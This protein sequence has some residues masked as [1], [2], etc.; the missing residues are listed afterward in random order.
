MSALLLL[1]YIQCFYSACI[2][3]CLSFSGCHFQS[4]LSSLSSLSLPPFNSSWIIHSCCILPLFPVCVHAIRLPFYHLSI[5]FL[6]PCTAS[7]FTSFCP[8][9]ASFPLSL[10]LCPAL[11]HSLCLSLSVTVG[12]RSAG[13]LGWLVS[14]LALSLGG[15]Q[16]AS[17]A[18]WPAQSRQHY[19]SNTALKLHWLGAPV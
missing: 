3:A 4:L 7:L 17:G 14:R 18:H 19:C 10:P 9:N 6:T 12:Y 2:C 8:P 11:S 13:R 5:C 15:M 16:A 1:G